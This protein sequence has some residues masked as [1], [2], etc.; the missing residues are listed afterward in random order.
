MTR[1]L[2]AIAFAASPV[3]ALAASLHE[4]PVGTRV[5][6]SF[7]LGP[8]RIY[9]P[10]GDWTLIAKHTWTGS[11]NTVMQGSSFAGVYLAELKEAR[12]TRAI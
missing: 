7:Q 3:P 12:L 4:Q 1:L 10:A 8:K 9:V 5:S 11:I 6:G 2:L